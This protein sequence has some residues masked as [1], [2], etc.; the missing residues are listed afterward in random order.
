M[1]RH[2]IRTRDLDW[3]SLPSGRHPFN[4]DSEMKMARLGDQTGMKRVLTNLVRLPP[5]KESFIAHSHA[6]EEEFIFILEGAGEVTL[7]GEAHAVGPGDFIGF[8]TDG[9]VHGFRNT[10]TSDLLYL[11]SGERARVEIAQMPSI[12]KTTVFRPGRITMFGDDGVEELT[13]EEWGARTKLP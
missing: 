11:T 10:G 3:S 8:P 13:P 9:V 12:G 2:I 5:G 7:D 1:D 6:V 4:P